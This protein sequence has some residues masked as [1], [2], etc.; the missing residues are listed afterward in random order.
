M[1]NE[2]FRNFN[3][4][5]KATASQKEI[6]RKKAQE[7]GLSLSEWIVTTLDIYIE[8]EELKERNKNQVYR[9]K[10]NEKEKLV[11][12]YCKESH[13]QNLS[14]KTKQNKNSNEVKLDLDKEIIQLKSVSNS[15][16]QIGILAFIGA[17]FLGK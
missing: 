7:A 2:N 16:Y 12:Y 3:V 6:Y 4:C 11:Y 10:N 17:M 13:N 14:E 8:Q 1:K 9:D 5:G 15:F